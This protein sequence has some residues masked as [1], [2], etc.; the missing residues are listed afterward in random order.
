LC[1][2]SGS[3]KSTLTAWLTSNGYQYL[4]DEV[5]ALPFSGEEVRGFCRSLVLKRGSEMI[6]KNWQPKAESRNFFKLNDG[7]VWVTPTFLNASA[8][9]ASVEPHMILFP[10][11]SAEAE[12]KVEKLTSAKTLFLLLQ[13]L[14]NA[15]NF[16]DQ[17]INTVKKL[18]QKVSAYQFVYSDIEQAAEWI[19]KK[20]TA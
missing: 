18:S 14:V 5:I 13:C 8:V 10:T 2:K 15:R 16:E 11:Y 17:G 20:I 9:R 3:G 4:S 1:G 7:S 6:W 12:F 19:Q